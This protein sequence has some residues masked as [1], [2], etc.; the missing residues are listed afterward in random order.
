MLSKPAN[1]LFTSSIFAHVKSK[2]ARII[3]P[4]SASG[5]F[6]HSRINLSDGKRK[7]LY[8]KRTQIVFS[9]A[10]EKA[11]LIDQ[12][13]KKRKIRLVKEAKKLIET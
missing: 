12:R 8:N 6:K 2:C 9:K 10:I 4:N 5:V 3:F 7:K 13:L 1:R 11:S